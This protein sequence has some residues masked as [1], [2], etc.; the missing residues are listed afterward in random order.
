M[1]QMQ[2][3]KYT[4]IKKVDVDLQQ[5]EPDT[6]GPPHSV[7]K[8]YTNCIDIV[9]HY[10]SQLGRDYKTRC[11]CYHYKI[12]HVTIVINIVVSINRYWEY[13]SFDCQ[14]ITIYG[15]FHIWQ[16]QVEAKNYCY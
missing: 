8:S 6:E 13:S 1:K 16:V 12:T 11:L 3:P 5:L 7:G 2:H 14:H 4:Q 10:N 9:V 15:S